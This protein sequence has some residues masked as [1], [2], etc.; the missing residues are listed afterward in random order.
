MFAEF[1]SKAIKSDDQTEVEVKTIL[2]FC[3]NWHISYQRRM[4]LLSSRDNTVEFWHDGHFAF[5]VNVPKSVFNPYTGPI[6]SKF[7]ELVFHG[8]LDVNGKRIID[9]GAGSGCMGLAAIL[10]GAKEILFTDLSQEAISYLKQQEF[11]KDRSDQFAVQDFL[12]ETIKTELAESKKFD[13]VFG[14][15]PTLIK[16]KDKKMQWES[17]K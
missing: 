4:E 13:L 6:G 2:Q 9:L 15:L 1:I 10:M 7:I 17:T 14:S 12:S 5:S 16:G 11:F 3:S 8:D